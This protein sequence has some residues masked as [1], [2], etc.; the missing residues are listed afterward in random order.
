ME[1]S[2]RKKAVLAEIIRSYIRYGE[3]VSSKAL[4]EMLD[5]GVSSATMRNEM[6]ELSEEGYLKQPHTSAGRIPTNLGYRF[7]VADLMEKQPVSAD[8]KSSIDNLLEKASHDPEHLMSVAGMILSDITGLP[9]I[10]SASS[11]EEAYIKRAEALPVGRRMVMIALLS[12]DGQAKSRLCRTARDITPPMLARLDRILS[13]K[14]VGTAV[15][16]FGSELFKTFIADSGEYAL[17]LTPIIGSVFEMAEE[18]HS[19]KLAIKGESNLISFYKNE[20][21]AKAVLDLV[22]EQQKFLSL[23][24]GMNDPVGVIFG[25]DTGIEE[26]RPSNMVIAKYNLSGSVT[27]RIGVLGPTRMAYEQVIPGIKY[28]ASKLSQVITDSLIDMEE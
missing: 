22:T 11:N 20:K 24:E 19:A 12:S 6:S 26:L 18:I 10:I 15:S 25:S 28:F 17:S 2:E 3:P 14:A 9:T 23:I 16:G 27:G 13:A 7:F 8:M 4:C 21:D 1:L 5:L